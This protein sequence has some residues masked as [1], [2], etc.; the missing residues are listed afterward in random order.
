[1]GGKWEVIVNVVM[2]DKGWGEGTLYGCSKSNGHCGVMKEDSNDGREMG[3][4]S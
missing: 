4:D 3:G 2:G 1:M